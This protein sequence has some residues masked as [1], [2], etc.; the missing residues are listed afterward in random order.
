MNPFTWGHNWYVLSLGESGRLRQCHCWKKGQILRW[1][2]SYEPSNRWFDSF[3]KMLV[4]YYK[5]FLSSYASHTP[6]V[7]Q[8]AKCTPCIILHT[9]WIPGERVY[10][11]GVFRVL[12]VYKYAQ[13]LLEAAHGSFSTFT[14]PG[15]STHPHSHKK[16]EE[17]WNLISAVMTMIPGKLLYRWVF[18]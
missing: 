15:F 17:N 7:V 3:D 13:R 1:K 16:K 6:C 8:T 5:G 10:D 4:R 14:L 9:S 12:D 18:F 11:V 2:Q